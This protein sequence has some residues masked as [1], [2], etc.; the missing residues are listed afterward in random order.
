[1]PDA[2]DG[3]DTLLASVPAMSEGEIDELF[4]A[5]VHAFGQRDLAVL[6][7]LWTPD[8]RAWHSVDCHAKDR[9]EYLAFI[10]NLPKRET[11]FVDPRRTYFHNGFVQQHI[12]E[13]I[14]PD[15]PV[16][17]NYICLVMRMENGLI[18]R[19]D[20]YITFGPVMP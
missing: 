17:R 11:R 8:I 13:I 7:S 9:D 3:A 5:F 16:D 20:E 6:A 2:I 12:V 1:M 10:A 19:I 14:P 4:Q 18:S 15:G